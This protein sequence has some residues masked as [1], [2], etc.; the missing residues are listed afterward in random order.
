MLS[1]TVQA[2]RDGREPDLDIAAPAGAEISLHVPALLPD[3]Y[4]PDV[5]LRLVHYKRIASAQSDDELQR[6]QIELMDR[7]GPLPE[8]TR[9]LFR[10][11]SIRLLVDPLGIDRLE[12]S[13]Q[14]ALVE[15]GPRT[16]I[17][18]ATLVH[19]LES[20]PDRFRL[21]RQQ[22][23]KI[24]DHV[25]EQDRFDYAVELIGLLTCA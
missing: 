6:L 4:L 12:V 21:D 2:L 15:F 20:E 3:D 10:S 16:S 14:G 23:L 25:A 9:N 11:T 17:D 8:P 18:P 22:R 7:F 13:A 5:H 19:L 1:R 24:R